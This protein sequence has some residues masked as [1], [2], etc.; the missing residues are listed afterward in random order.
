MFTKER[1]WLW[2]FEEEKDVPAGWIYT[3]KWGDLSMSTVVLDRNFDCFDGDLESL[4]RAKMA[5]ELGIFWLGA[6]Q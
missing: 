6:S 1:Y 4:V 2:D 3:L 5:K